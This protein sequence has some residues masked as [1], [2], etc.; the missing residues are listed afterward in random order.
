MIPRPVADFGC[1]HFCRS[2]DFHSPNVC[3]FSPT[4]ISPGCR[5]FVK[6]GTR[7]Q[8]WLGLQAENFRLTQYQHTANV[9]GGWNLLRQWSQ[10]I[11]PLSEK[12]LVNVICLPRLL[13]DSPPIRGELDRLSGAK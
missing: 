10:E 8:S 3:T 6:A 13:G 7:S 9:S 2:A 11:W 12:T 5:S 4:R 1:V